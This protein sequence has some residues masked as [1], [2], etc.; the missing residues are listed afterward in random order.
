MNAAEMRY[1]DFSRTGNVLILFIKEKDAQLAKK[2]DLYAT[3]A[4]F[5]DNEA[6]GFEY[7]EF[8]ADVLGL[9]Y[10]VADYS[11]VPRSSLIWTADSIELDRTVNYEIEF[12]RLLQMWYDEQ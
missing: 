8:F 11:E 4:W 2:C 1:Y 12:R 5:L 10:E 7:F 3:L 6:A 9:D